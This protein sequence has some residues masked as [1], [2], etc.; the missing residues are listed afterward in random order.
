MAIDGSTQG[1]AEPTQAWRSTPAQ[2]FAIGATDSDFDLD[3][4]YN[5]ETDKGAVRDLTHAYEEHGRFGDSSSGPKSAQEAVGCF[6]TG[7]AAQC[8]TNCSISV[9]LDA[10]S[11]EEIKGNTTVTLSCEGST[12]ET[13]KEAED[14]AKACRRHYSSIVGGLGIGARHAVRAIEAAERR[15]VRDT[16]A[17]NRLMKTAK[18][19]RE[20]TI[21]TVLGFS[22]G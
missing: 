12:F 2:E 6:L 16:E 3:G 18:D 7:R 19:T 20:E 17:A 13:Q 1:L 5:Y 8:A 11:S 15:A 9:T 14:A 10:A 22:L 4:T 21:A